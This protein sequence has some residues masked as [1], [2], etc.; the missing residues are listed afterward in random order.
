VAIF[1]ADRI[2]ENKELMI[3]YQIWCPTISP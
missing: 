1:V 2:C 3:K